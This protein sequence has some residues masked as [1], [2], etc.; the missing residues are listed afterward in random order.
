MMNKKLLSFGVA[1]LFA[2]TA[3]EVSCSI[4]KRMAQCL[5]FVH[6]HSDDEQ[7]AEAFKRISRG[8]ELISAGAEQCQKDRKLR[9]LGE[10]G[11]EKVAQSCGG[12][13]SL[14]LV[15]V[16]EKEAILPKDLLSTKN[17]DSL[18]SFQASVEAR[19]K[20][21][22]NLG[23]PKSLTPSWPLETPRNVNEEFKKEVERA[24]PAYKN[25]ALLSDFVELLTNDHLGRLMVWNAYHGVKSKVASFFGKK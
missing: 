4:V 12:L 21:K 1:I 22:P 5:K 11:E 23:D 24:I 14:I 10:I 25:E 20:T 15:S 17:P 2:G 18:A 9:D 16:A 19:K 8:K 13:A 6:D 3:T 7:R